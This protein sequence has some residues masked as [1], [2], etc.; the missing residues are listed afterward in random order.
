MPAQ[1]V[2]QPF[3]H[4]LGLC[5]L[6]GGGEHQRARR[7]KQLNL[8]RQVIESPD[9]EDDPARQLGVGE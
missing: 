5:L 8:P 9:P 6:L 4:V 2:A 3:R 1:R 7:A